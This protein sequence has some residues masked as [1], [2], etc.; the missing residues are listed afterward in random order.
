MKESMKSVLKAKGLKNA[1]D[2]LKRERVVWVEDGDI[3]VRL[4]LGVESVK[5]LLCVDGDRIDEILEDHSETYGRVAI[6]EA[7]LDY[8]CGVLKLDSDGAKA[9]IKEVLASVAHRV[10]TKEIPTEVKLTEASISEIGLTSIE[11][12]EAVQKHY[13]LEK[14]FLKAKRELNMCHGLVKAMEQRKE[15]LINRSARSRTALANDL[16]NLKH[17]VET[18]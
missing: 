10:R 4:P 16:S 7:D 18:E 2:P 17:M 11:Y 5:R 1:K 9:E 13:S 12:R 3:K 14:K 6:Q 15:C 8:V